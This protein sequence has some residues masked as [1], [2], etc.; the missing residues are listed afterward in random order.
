MRRLLMLASL[1]LM[2]IFVF[3]ATALAQQ[4]DDDQPA[5]TGAGG[6]VDVVDE[7]VTA[8][9]FGGDQMGGAGGG[10][11]A[12]ATASATATASSTATTS[13]TATT[14]STSTTTTTTTA[15]P[16]ASP[17][18]TTTATTT[19]TALARTGGPEPVLLFTLM[20]S[21]MLIGSGVAALVLLRR[22][23]RVEG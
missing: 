6:K 11:T 3:A 1:S 9:E 15:S 19:V 22:S 4:Y 18:A 8:G 17:T 5:A 23:L 10:T 20:A 14:T 12:S 16:T 13:A 7:P 2:A 21:L